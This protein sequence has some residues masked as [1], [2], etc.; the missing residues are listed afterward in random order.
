MFDHMAVIVCFRANHHNHPAV[1][2]GRHRGGER[3]PA[4]SSEPRPISGAQIH[5]VLQRAGHPLREPRW[6]L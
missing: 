2:A 3:G 1:H 5:L 4:L 6:I